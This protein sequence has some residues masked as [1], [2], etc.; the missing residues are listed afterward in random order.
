MGIVNV[1]NTRVAFIIAK[2]GVVAFTA[3]QDAFGVC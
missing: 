1:V 3:E 2:P